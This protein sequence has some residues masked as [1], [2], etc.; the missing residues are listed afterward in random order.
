[1]S[2][3]E[4]ATND[5]N[6]SW[7]TEQ[8]PLSSRSSRQG[9]IDRHHANLVISKRRKW[10][11]QENKII[12]EC[13][14]LSEPKIGGYRKHMLSLW[15]H[16]GMFWVSKQR[17]VDQT[18]IIHS[19]SWMTEIDIEDLERKVTGSDSI[20]VEEA[21]V[22]ALLDHAGQDVRNALPKMGVEEQADSLDEEEV[23]I[24]MKIAVKERGRKDKSTALRNVPKKKLLEET[25]LADK[26]FSKFETE[27]YKD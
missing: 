16:M 21:S 27:F 20:I 7:L 12:M 13:Y 19:N 18:N 10:T 24:T 5:V 2:S 1:M 11:S 9:N 3:N 6:E 23:T 14:L 15:L 8:G 4:I 17:S 26:V 22:E 25:A